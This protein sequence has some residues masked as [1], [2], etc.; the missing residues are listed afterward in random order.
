M[1]LAKPINKHLRNEWGTLPTY[2]KTT[3]VRNQNAILQ[4]VGLSF[5]LF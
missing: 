2:Q 1:Q 5:L 4:S 3:T